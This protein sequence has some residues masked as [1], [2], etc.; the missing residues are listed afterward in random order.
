MLCHQVT[1]KDVNVLP[2]EISTQFLIFFRT[3]FGDY[4]KYLDSQ[5]LFNVNGFLQGCDPNHRKVY[6]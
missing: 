4:K 1:H 6:L 2:E 3:I 5:K